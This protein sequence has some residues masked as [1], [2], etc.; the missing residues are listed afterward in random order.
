M[1]RQELKRTESSKPLKRN[2]FKKANK[3]Q[4]RV[5]KLKNNKEDDDF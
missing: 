5:Q 3:K 4:I 1:A 2:M